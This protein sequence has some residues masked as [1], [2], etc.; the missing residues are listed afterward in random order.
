MELT[1]S[2]TVGPFFSF[3]LCTNPEDAVLVARD[4]RDAITIRGRVIDG[5]GQGV[6]DALVEIWQPDASGRYHP[7]SS[8]GFSSF[9][10]CGTDAEGSFEFV[11]VKPG[12]IP[13][14]G[15]PSQAP[16]IDVLVFS[17]GLLKQLVTRI[18]FPDEDANA[19][20]P[21]LS[22]IED[23]SEKATLVAIREGEA[24]FRFDVHMQGEDQTVFLAV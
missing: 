6:S 5:V 7:A 23:P 19:T 8:D 18:Y 21:L 20:D 9:G 22:S 2:Q 16:H 10:R 17:R 12:V 3:G 15:G 1:P 24:V 11:T 13:A 4:A 14:N